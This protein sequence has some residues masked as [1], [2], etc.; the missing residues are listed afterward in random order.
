[1][2]LYFSAADDERIDAV[3][4]DS[5]AGTVHCYTAFV[6]K[7]RLPGRPSQKEVR[8]GGRRC[9]LVTLMPL[10]MCVADLWKN[11]RRRRRSR[12]GVAARS[13]HARRLHVVADAFAAGSYR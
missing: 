6:H 9:F 7:S 3:V 1:V 12:A 8:R 10:L 5:D 4:D 11:R 13:E 2:V